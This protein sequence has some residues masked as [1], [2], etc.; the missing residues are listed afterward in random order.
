MHSLTTVTLDKAFAFRYKKTLHTKSFLST[1]S[2]FL[3]ITSA[4]QDY[5]G[6]PPS[7]CC[8]SIISPLY[9]TVFNPPSHTC[10][11][12]SHI[13][14]TLLHTILSTRKEKGRRVIFIISTAF[15]CSP[16]DTFTSSHK[17]RLWVLYLEIN[18]RIT[19]TIMS[20]S[21]KSLLSLLKGDGLNNMFW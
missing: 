5:L 4:L 7:D 20:F 11:Y 1:S 6:I 12:P 15:I 3:E 2:S 9:F 16:S 18:C 8:C 14:L 13:S 10:I 21:T 17:A 19:M